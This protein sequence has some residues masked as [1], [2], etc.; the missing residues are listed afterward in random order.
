MPMIIVGVGGKSVRPIDANVIRKRTTANDVLVWP[1]RWGNVKLT[2]SQRSGVSRASDEIGALIAGT[3]L[4][5]QLSAAE[6]R[7]E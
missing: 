4:V 2:P 5:G 6:V 3:E 1:S 7:R